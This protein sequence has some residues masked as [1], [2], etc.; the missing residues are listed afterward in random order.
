VP[1]IIGLVFDALNM[2]GGTIDWAGLPTVMELLGI[3]DT[4]R[5]IRLMRIVLNHEKS[6]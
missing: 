1:P 6:N 4:E 3:G 5:M 2:M